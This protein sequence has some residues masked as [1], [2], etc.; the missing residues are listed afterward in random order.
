MGEKRKRKRRRDD[1]RSA[2]AVTDSADDGISAETAATHQP[3]GSEYQANGISSLHRPHASSDA[4]QDVVMESIDQRQVSPDLYNI[5]L[6]PVLPG[7]EDPTSPAYKGTAKKGK[8]KRKRARDANGEQQPHIDSFVSVNQDPDAADP[9][10]QDGLSKPPKRVPSK[11]KR[12]VP[13]DDSAH[14]VSKRPKKKRISLDYKTAQLRKVSQGPGLNGIDEGPREGPFT[15]AEIARLFAFR[16]QWCEEND[17]TQQ[18]F[19]A[20]IHANAHNNVKNIGFWNEVSEVLPY[21]TR[22]SLQ[23][24]CRRRFHNFTKRGIWTAE[25]DEELREAHAEHGNRWKVIGEQIER[26]PEDCRD[27]WRNYLKQSEFRNRDEWTEY[28]VDCLKSA[29]AGS[30]EAMRKADRKERKG[31]AAARDRV[32][33]QDGEEKDTINWVI[34]SAKLGG[35]R[36]RLQCSYKWKQLG[37][38]AKNP[39]KNSSKDKGRGSKKTNEWRKK[40]PKEKFLYMLP[41]D[42]YEILNA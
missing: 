27:R 26:L 19:I 10:S 38:K 31:K 3:P 39:E 36:S 33:Q 37:E 41:G 32:A 9:L 40:R 11:R 12:P 17:C 34:V 13:A 1:T 30:M 22:H 20:Q 42:K 14:G 15:D 18:Q 24:V 6:D 21:R 29:V 35:S 2:V 23:R 16:D 28:E 25:E 5:P 4:E 7:I 8:R